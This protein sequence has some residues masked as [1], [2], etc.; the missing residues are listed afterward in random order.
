MINLLIS[1]GLVLIEIFNNNMYVCNKQNEGP[2]QK[3]HWLRVVLDE[4]HMIRNPAAQMTKMIMSL[5]TERK[6]IVTGESMSG[7]LVSVARWLMGV[8]QC[9]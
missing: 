2:L 8:I 1:C 4:G 3:I 7:G 9:Y 5:N 6:W